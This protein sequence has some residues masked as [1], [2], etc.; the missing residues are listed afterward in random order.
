M[1]KQVMSYSLAEDNTYK[2]SCGILSASYDK[3]WFS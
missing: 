1:L 3:L 2:I